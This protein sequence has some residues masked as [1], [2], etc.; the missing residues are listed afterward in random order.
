MPPRK[1]HRRAGADGR[2]MRS[3]LAGSGYERRQIRLCWSGPFVRTA[4]VDD[5]HRAGSP[6]LRRT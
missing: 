4:V 5:S 3:S 6:E 2:G 1:H